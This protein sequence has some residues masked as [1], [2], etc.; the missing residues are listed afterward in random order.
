[1]DEALNR[2]DWDAFVAAL[3]PAC[4]VVD[5]RRSVTVPLGT[6]LIGM[7]RTL[8]SLDEWRLQ[9]TPVANEG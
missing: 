2:R 9:R 7:F 8:F 1:M 3:D 6:D 5:R 4:E